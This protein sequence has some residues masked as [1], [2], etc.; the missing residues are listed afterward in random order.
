MTLAAFCEGAG[1][2]SPDERPSVVHDHPALLVYTSGTT[3][4]SKAVM[5]PERSLLFAAASTA[6]FYGLTPDDR[7]Y[8]V[9]PYHHMNAVMA[10]GLIPMTAGAQS[11]VGDSFGFTNAKFYWTDVARLG[12][13]VPSLTPSI[14][15]MLLKLNPHGTPAALDGVRFTWCGAAPLP[16]SL[17]REFEERFGIPVY[18]GY[19]LTETSFWT[20]CI[21]PDVPRHYDTVGIPVDCEVRIDTDA[22]TAHGTEPV[23]E[24]WEAPEQA[25]RSAAAQPPLGEILIRSGGLMTGYYKNRKLTSVVMTPDGFLRTGDIGFVDEEGYLRIVARKKEIIIRNGIN[26]LPDELDAVI[27]EHPAVKECKT[28]GVPDDYLG[29]RIVAVCVLKDDSGSADARGSVRSY[30]REQLSSFKRPDDVVILSGLP[31]GITG[32][33]AS[34]TLRRIISGEVTDEI[35]GALTKRKFRRAEPKKVNE[36]RELVDRAVRTGEPLRFVKYWGVGERDSLNEADELGLKTLQELMAAVSVIP[37]VTATLTLILNNMHGRMNGRIPE[38]ASA[39]LSQIAEKARAAGFI[40]EFEDAV[41]EAGGLDLD[42]ITREAATPERKTWFEALPVNDKL[43]EQ[44]TKHSRLRAGEEGA[45]LYAT[46]CQHAN[47]LLEKRYAGHI[48]L[49]YNP[50]ELDIVSPDLPRLYIFPYRRGNSNK[51]WFTP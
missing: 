19:G 46:A 30:A 10:T 18:Q 16:E 1:R 3:G 43:A 4:G 22:L 35:V 28:I 27:R 50:P 9:L 6:R 48:F 25:T 36:I 49:T 38:R 37:K 7:V 45:R 32:K 51:P 23:E 12:V 31:R 20:V 8:G 15:S 14:M 40:V 34:G 5:L 44:A 21:P 47:R 24:A 2:C 11:V 42:A 29:E 33:V 26:I 39:Y 13:T 41:W 17:W